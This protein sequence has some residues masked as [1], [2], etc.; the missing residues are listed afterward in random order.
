MVKPRLE[1]AQ[2]STASLNEWHLAHV[3]IRTESVNQVICDKLLVGVVNGR[4]S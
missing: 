3:L 4:L 1:D 2:Y